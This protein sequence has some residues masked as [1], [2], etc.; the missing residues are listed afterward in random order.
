MTILI[1]YLSMRPLPVSIL[2]SSLLDLLFL[3][4]LKAHPSIQ[5]SIAGYLLLRRQSSNVN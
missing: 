5:R 4:L 1:Y 2:G 3:I